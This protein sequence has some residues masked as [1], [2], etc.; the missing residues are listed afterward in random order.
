[1]VS[2]RR[3]TEKGCCEQENTNVGSEW[4]AP[5]KSAARRSAFGR[6]SKMT[7]ACRND[8]GNIVGNDFGMQKRRTRILM[9]EFGAQK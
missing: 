5:K 2:S 9:N 8:H 3:V 1:M 6:A 4:G 7:S